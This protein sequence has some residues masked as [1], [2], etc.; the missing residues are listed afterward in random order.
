M[1][2]DQLPYL[3][4]EHQEQHEEYLRAIP[5]ME[6]ASELPTADDKPVE[7]IGKLP[8]G[9]F[10][11]NAFVSEIRNAVT[12]GAISAVDMEIRLAALEKLIKAI[13]TDVSIREVVLSEAPKYENSSLHGYEIKVKTR[14]N[15]EYGG[16]SKW[17]DLQAKEKF[18]GDQR[19]AREKFLQ[20]LPSEMADPETG[21][22]IQPAFQKKPTVFIEVKAKK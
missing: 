10:E 3:R 4:P 1:S 2:E 9:D 14:R 11:M 5:E 17:I 8:L 19:K 7:L 6:A 13:R 20:T 15:Y 16:D 12:E 18:Y 22:I 21:E